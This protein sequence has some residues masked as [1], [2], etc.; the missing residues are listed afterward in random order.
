MRFSLL[1]L[2]LAS[3]LLWAQACLI[4]SNDEQLP[5]RLCQQN[6]SIPAALFNEGFCQPQIP[7]RSF[8]VVFLEQCPAGAYGV[9]EGARTAGVAYEQAIHYYTD[10]DDAPVLKAYCESISQGRWQIP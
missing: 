4:T 1:T 10:E 7:E 5:V 3:P 2:L 6:I 8:D 9:C